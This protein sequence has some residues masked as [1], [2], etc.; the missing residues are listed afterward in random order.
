MALAEVNKKCARDESPCIF[1]F[2]EA[3]SRTRGQGLAVKMGIFYSCERCFEGV[4]GRGG[5]TEGMATPAAQAAKR[6][7]RVKY[8]I[9]HIREAVII[10]CPKT[11]GV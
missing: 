9:Y 1:A 8:V 6:N 11:D 7:Y 2:R 5:C 4:E 3:A 10:V